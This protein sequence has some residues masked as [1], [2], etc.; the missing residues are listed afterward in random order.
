MYISLSDLGLFIFFSVTII[1][2]VYLI[3]VLR[4]ILGVLGHIQGIFEAHDK[5]IQKT[6]SLLPEVLENV[7]ELTAN[8]KD[9]FNHTS[10]AL[11]TLQDDLLDDLQ[12]GLET[13]A[14]YAKAIGSI[15]RTVFSK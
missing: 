5:D 3:A 8:L 4:R 1:I 14:I 15:F 12:N 6:L 9:T 2:A 13:F 10:D 11:C 7:N